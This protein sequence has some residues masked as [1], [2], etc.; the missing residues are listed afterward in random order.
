[1]YAAEK[2]RCTPPGGLLP[3]ET[4]K[5]VFAYRRELGDA[6]LT[7]VLN[8]SDKPAQSAI[9]GTLVRSNYP[10]RGFTGSLQPWEAVILEEGET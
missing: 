9:R 5:Q 3:L 8:F 4:G 10:R 7:M 6:S 1:M 2:Q